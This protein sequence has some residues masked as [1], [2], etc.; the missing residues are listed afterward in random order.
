MAIFPYIEVEEYKFI[1]E[2]PKS[3]YRTGSESAT[4]RDPEEYEGTSTVLY[5]ILPYFC[6]PNS[7]LQLW[8]L[9]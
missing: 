5:G 9:L 2:Q 4:I 7:V 6:T 3:S 8:L 1:I